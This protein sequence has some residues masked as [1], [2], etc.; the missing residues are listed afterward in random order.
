MKFRKTCFV[1]AW[2]FVTLSAAQVAHAQLELRVSVK[3]VHLNDGTPPGLDPNCSATN[4][5]SE[6][7]DRFDYANAILARHGRGYQFRVVDV[8]NLDPPPLPPPGFLACQSGDRFGRTCESDDDCN[9]GDCSEVTEWSRAPVG[10][11]TRATIQT[12]ARANPDDFAYDPDAHNIYIID[13]CNSGF[14]STLL[15]D[16]V[17]GQDPDLV[18]VVLM[19]QRHRGGMLR[20]FHELGHSMGICHVHGCP[21]WCGDGNDDCGTNPITFGD[22]CLDDTLPDAPC[23]DTV[24]EIA[25]AQF[26]LMYD[27][28]G[29]ANKERVLDNAFNIMSYHADNDSG[30]PLDLDCPLDTLDFGCGDPVPV[31]CRHRL[32]DDQLDRLADRANCLWPTI[33][34]GRTRFV[35][36]NFIGVIPACASVPQ[37]NNFTAAVNAAS[38]GDII[39]VRSANYN[40]TITINKRLTLRSSRGVARIGAP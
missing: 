13:R 3:L 6:I 20:P 37:F 11:G 29:C 32:T 8:I 34:N 7:Q 14:S 17:D 1:T 25:M 26:S 16:S 38:P 39:N 5:P 36:R 30:Y 15:A 2:A 21:S 27:Q 28:L 18:P 12:E 31:V 10:P 4:T 19:G 24:D 33:T 35:D 9:G 23:V 40:E 22:D